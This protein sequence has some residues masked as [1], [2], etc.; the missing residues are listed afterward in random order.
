MNRS[1]PY[2]TIVIGA[3]QK[4]LFWLVGSRTVTWQVV[5]ARGQLGGGDV[6]AAAA[7]S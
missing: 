6:E 3:C 1:H 7:W 5:L 2:G 4:A